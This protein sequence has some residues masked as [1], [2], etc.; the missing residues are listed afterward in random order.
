MCFLSDVQNESRAHERGGEREQRGG[1]GPLNQ[2][3]VLLLNSLSVHGSP[4]RT[5][6]FIWRMG[7]R[8][9]KATK[10]MTA[11]ISTII[12][13]SSSAVSAPMR[14]LTLDS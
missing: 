11:P 3:V 6:E 2:S 13:G 1:D 4:H 7:I 10:A 9:E 8:M 14:T 5:I 12:I